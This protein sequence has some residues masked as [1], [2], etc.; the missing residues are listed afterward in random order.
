MNNLSLF[1]FN[2]KLVLNLFEMEDALWVG[3]TRPRLVFVF[4]TRGASGIPS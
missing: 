2:L 4:D 3:G 1:L